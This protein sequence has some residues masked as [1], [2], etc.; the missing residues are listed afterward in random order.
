M[1]KLLL[2]SCI[3][4]FGLLSAQ[5][6]PKTGSKSTPAKSGQRATTSQTLQKTKVID[7]FL[8]FDE[9]EH[10]YEFK[11]TY[12]DGSFLLFDAKADEKDYELKLYFPSKKSETGYEIT[13]MGDVNRDSYMDD[14][15]R[16]QRVEKIYKCKN[17]LEAINDKN[18]IMEY[19]RLFKNMAIVSLTDSTSYTA[20]Y[21]PQ[22]NGSELIRF[23]T[24][25][26]DYS[27]L[28]DNGNKVELSFRTYDRD[29]F[30]KPIDSRDDLECAVNIVYPDGTLKME[31]MKGN[32]TNGQPEVK[33]NSNQY[34]IDGFASNGIRNF[35]GGAKCY[36]S[37]GDNF[38][39]IPKTFDIDQL[40]TYKSIKEI[41]FKEGILTTSK[42][43]VYFSDGERDEFETKKLNQ[44]N[45]QR[46]EKYA[47]YQKNIDYYKKEFGAVHVNNF[48][49]LR[50]APGAPI[51]LFDQRLYTDDQ[52]GVTAK[53]RVSIDHGNS[54]CYDFNLSKFELNTIIAE[55][56]GWIWVTNGKV[57][58]VHY[59]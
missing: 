37:N 53:L 57:T 31:F 29:F 18:T 4:A 19:I 3:L 24:G 38:I 22:F 17:I 50:I 52:D 45:Q 36:Y 39:G 48:L 13:F 8:N 27:I 9:N 47:N 10:L 1:K 23:E 14:M 16:W 30:K 58:S 20:Y 42:E 56:R 34:F 11:K 26:L 44:A 25:C 46:L 40:S 15:N 55:R 33:I 5:N 51:K 12:S 54:K 35:K 43:M 7:D 41:P 21:K 49:S 6:A 32:A 28:N 59:Y 2:L